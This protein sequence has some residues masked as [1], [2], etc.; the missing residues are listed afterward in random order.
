MDCNFSSLASLELLFRPFRAIRSA[1]SV[2]ASVV[3]EGS[4]GSCKFSESFDTLSCVDARNLL[5]GGSLESTWLPFF[6]PNLPDS[7]AVDSPSSPDASREEA[8]NCS[9]VEGLA[10]DEGRVVLFRFPEPEPRDD[11]EDIVVLRRPNG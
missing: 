2:L 11:G 7:G 8:C 6:W 3:S 9:S 4:P 1:I 10:V 5:E